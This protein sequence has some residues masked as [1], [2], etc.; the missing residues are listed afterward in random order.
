M[1]LLKSIGDTTCVDS[2]NSNY[3]ISH[4]SFWMN[5][6]PVLL[7]TSWP[8][9]L[10]HCSRIFRGLRLPLVGRF[11]KSLTE[12]GG[13]I[14]ALTDKKAETTKPKNPA[15]VKKAVA[16]GRELTKKGDKTK[17][18]VAVEMFQYLEDEPREV[19]AQAFVD[20]AGL[21]PKGAM[22]YVYNV[23]RKFKK[24]T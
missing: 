11:V 6:V 18:D 2:E 7:A 19:I 15:N 8:T 13:Y 3:T 23:R 9:G 14:M 1:V 5:T 22:T 20:G 12:Y 17:V 4:S 10:P 24:A 16:L 21:T